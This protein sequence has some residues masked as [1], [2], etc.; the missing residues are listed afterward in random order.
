MA[1]V[2]ARVN[3]VALPTALLLLLSTIAAAKDSFRIEYFKVRGATAA[4]L[5]ADLRR[6]GPVGETGVIGGALTKY[7]IV[8]QISMTFEN[9]S[10][11]AEDV[12]VDLDVTMLL[13]R[14][15]PPAGVAPEVVQVWDRIS[16][17]LR[18]HE[19]GHHRLAIEAA[20]EVRRRLGKAVRADSC[21]ALKSRLNDTA[22]AVLREYRAK[23]AAYDE[24]TDYGRDQTSGLL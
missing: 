5:R 22:N 24:R 20:R 4:E 3:R 21:G 12:N 7:R 9:S 11:R 2:V 14:W 17:L 13:P 8:W 6:V 23:Q 18:E 1:A 10:C 19:D 16:A 15:E